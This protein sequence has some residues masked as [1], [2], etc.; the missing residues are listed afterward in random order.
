MHVTAPGWNQD[1]HYLAVIGDLDG[2]A[3]LHLRSTLLLLLRSS[4]C[5]IDLDITST[6]VATGAIEAISDRSNLQH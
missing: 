3:A 6:S 1:R 5:G 2:F 4:R